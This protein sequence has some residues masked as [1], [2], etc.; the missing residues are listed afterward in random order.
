MQ[1]DRT[2]IDFSQAYLT[3]Q[4]DESFG[5]KNLGLANLTISSI[6][7]SGDP[8]FTFRGTPNGTALRY[9]DIGAVTVTFAPNAVKTYQGTLTINS[10]VPSQTVTLKGSGVAPPP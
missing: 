4:P 10:N 9:N 6:S 8:V 2:S 3:T 1:I 7:Y 5:I